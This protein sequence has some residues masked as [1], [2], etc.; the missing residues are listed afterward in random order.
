MAEAQGD[1]NGDF[2][3]PP[4]LPYVSIWLTTEVRHPVS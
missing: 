2:A 3:R 1:E 4:A